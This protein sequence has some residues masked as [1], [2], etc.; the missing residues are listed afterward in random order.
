MFP[1]LDARTGRM[2][3]LRLENIRGGGFDRLSQ[4]LRARLAR[5]QVP[6]EELLSLGDEAFVRIGIAATH[7]LSGARRVYSLKYGLDEI[8]YGKFERGSSVRIVPY[9]ESE[10][11]A[12]E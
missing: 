3:S 2:Y 11:A 12:W 5:N 9:A 1:V 7:G 10:D 4:E 8:E 6:L